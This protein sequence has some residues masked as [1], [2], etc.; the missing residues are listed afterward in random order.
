MDSYSCSSDRLHIF[1][2]HGNSWISAKEEFLWASAL[3]LEKED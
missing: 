3:V 1:D 2:F